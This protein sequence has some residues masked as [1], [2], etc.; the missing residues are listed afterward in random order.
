MAQTMPSKKQGG[1]PAN[2]FEMAAG[3]GSTTSQ[4]SPSPARTSVKSHGSQGR[5]SV[6]GG[7]AGGR[8]VSFAG[9]AKAGATEE[10]QV[11][12]AALKEIKQERT[13]WQ[14]TQTTRFI[15]L[16]Q[17]DPQVH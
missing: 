14:S 17:V 10:V 13:L 2:P 11:S 12:A 15:E 16:P 4:I 6:G 1:G 8:S 5:L 3:A 9:G 7:R